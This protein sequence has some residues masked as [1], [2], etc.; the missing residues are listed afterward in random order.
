MKPNLSESAEFSSSELILALKG[1]LNTVTDKFLTRM[2]VNPVPGVLHTYT[3]IVV[4]LLVDLVG[5]EVLMRL[6]KKS[7][8]G[9]TEC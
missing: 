3:R 2:K 4:K 8:K 1:K 6:V 5:E 7:V 9:G